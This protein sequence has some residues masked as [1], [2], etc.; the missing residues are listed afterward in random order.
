MKR[1][2]SVSLGASS[3]DHVTEVEFLGQR[4]RL[5][6]RGTDGN[7]AKALELF[8]QNDGRVDAF[9]VGGT[10]LYQEI[11]GRRYYWKDSRPIQEAVRVSKIGDGNRVKSV[12]ARKAVEALER[13]LQRYG[14]TLKGMPALMTAAVDRYSMAEALDQA[15]CRMVIGDFMFALGLPL[16]MHSMRTLRFA[17][18]LLMP[19]ITRLP[20][21][22]F[23]SVGEE[24]EKEPEQRWNKYYE[25]AEVIAGDY[26]Q[27][28]DYMPLDL[29]GKIVVTN[30]TTRNDMEELAR[31]G[32]SLLATTTPRLEGRSFG[33][34]VIEATLLALIDKPQSEITR[35]DLAELIERIPIEPGIERLNSF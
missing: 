33:T 18:A 7:L 21:R 3:R 23:Y 12:L 25:E 30:T 9:G 4:C 1:I 5:E 27:I 10:N 29:R 13:H 11:A 31:R 28:R 22:W 20:F 17:A 32:L 2:L 15:G 35:E 8:R 24:Q 34:N 14:R 6:R 16:P 26:L 19:I